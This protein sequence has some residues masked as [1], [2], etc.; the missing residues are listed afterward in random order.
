MFDFL[1]RFFFGLGHCG[2]GAA[3]D[4]CCSG[5]GAR[6]FLL[7]VGGAGEGCEIHHDGFGAFIAGQAARANVVSIAASASMNSDHNQRA[8]NPAAKIVVIQGAAAIMRFSRLR[9]MRF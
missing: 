6:S 4:C 7:S 5:P 8:E 1:L 9:P 3:F 2:L